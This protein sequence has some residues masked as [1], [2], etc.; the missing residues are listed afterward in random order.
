MDL[1]GR[2]REDLLEHGEWHAVEAT[3]KTVL[4]RGAGS[5]RQRES[6]QSGGFTE[7]VDM[8]VAETVASVNSGT[9]ARA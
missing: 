7:V 1:V 8:A 2:L 5:T 6:L 3:V 4:A 9:N